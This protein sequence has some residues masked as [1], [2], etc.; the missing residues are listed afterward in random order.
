MW[1]CPG[2]A[3][4]RCRSRRD[5]YRSMPER[6][7][8]NWIATALIGSRCRPRV[9]LRSTFPANFPTCAWSFGLSADSPCGR[10]GEQAPMTENP[11]A[12]PDD[13]DRTIIRP[14]AAPRPVA[15]ATIVAPAPK[16]Q[17]ATPPV[18]DVVAATGESPL[19]TAAFPLLQ[20]LAR[21]RNTLTPPDSGDLRERAA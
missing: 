3:S 17:R 4:V 9:D 16:M 2:S 18:G 7:I 13:D 1:L 14:V 21:L 5:R 19:L 10:Q 12:E 11:F 6:P 8:S 15:D 20:L